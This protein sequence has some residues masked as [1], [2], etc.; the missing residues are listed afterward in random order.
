MKKKMA[1]G[2]FLGKTDYLGQNIFSKHQV[3]IPT[4]DAKM[5]ISTRELDISLLVRNWHQL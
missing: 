2:S 4:K 3:I 1:L 5:S